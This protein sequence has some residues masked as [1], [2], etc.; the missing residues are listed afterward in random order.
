MVPLHI[1]FE[2]LDESRFNSLLLLDDTV[3][4]KSLRLMTGKPNMKNDIEGRYLF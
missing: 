1:Q 3:H 4:M 2:E